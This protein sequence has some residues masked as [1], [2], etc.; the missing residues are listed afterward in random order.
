MDFY[1]EDFHVNHHCA[2]QV[3]Y[4]L[5]DRSRV[6]CLMPDMAIEYDWDYK[7]AECIG[8]ALHY[9]VETGRKAGCVLIVKDRGKA[10]KYIY[11][12]NNATKYTD[13]TLFVIEAITKVAK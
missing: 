12:F 4:V 13:V 6:D 1:N 10:D 9:A 11:R 7:W 5:Q 2:G 3:E 8:Q